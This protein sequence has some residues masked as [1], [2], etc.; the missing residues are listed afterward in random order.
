M[1][2]FI[3]AGFVWTGYTYETESQNTGE[4]GSDTIGTVPSC[5]PQRLF[6]SSVPLSSDDGEQW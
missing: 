5:Y 6:G 3:R 4:N 2:L 1:S